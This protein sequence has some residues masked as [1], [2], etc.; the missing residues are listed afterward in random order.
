VHNLSNP[1]LRAVVNLVREWE[2]LRE[3]C[4]REECQAECLREECLREVFMIIRS[5]G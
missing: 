5:S 4:L 3:E 1:L 2:C